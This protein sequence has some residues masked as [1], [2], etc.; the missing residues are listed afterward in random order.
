MRQSGNH[1]REQSG[2]QDRP[3]IPVAVILLISLAALWPALLNGGPFFMADTPSYIRGAASGFY[4]VFGLKTEWAHEFL[5][6]YGGALTDQAR[7]L[8]AG[9]AGA[10]SSSSGGQI[11]VTLS[12]RSI[13]YGAIL[14]LAYLAGSFWLV[15]V[16]QSV[17]AAVS[18]MFTIEAICSAAGVRAHPRKVLLIGLLAMLASPLAFFADYLMPDLF[19]GLA[20]LAA[21]NILFLWRELSH[22]RRGFWLALLTYSLLSHSVNLMMVAALSFIAVVLAWQRAIPVGRHPVVGI[23]V[24]L[25]TAVFGELAFAQAVVMA[26][27]APPVRPPFVAM[28]LIADGPGYDYLREHCPTKRFIYCRAVGQRELHHDSLLWSSDPNVSL[29]RGL[30]PQEQRQSAAQQGRFVTAVIRDRPL[31]VLRSASSNFLDQL[32]S[33]DL[34]VFNYTSGNRDRFQESVPAQLYEPITAT[35]AFRESMPTRAV[36][37][38]SAVAALMS[39]LT[40]MYFLISARGGEAM[41]RLRGHALCIMAGIMLNAAICGALSGPIGRYGMRVIWVLPVIAA[42]I[43]LTGQLRWRPRS[44]GN[45]G[46]SALA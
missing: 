38:L 24:C 43:V 13:F 33:F 19:G 1:A 37:T 34:N 10:A 2:A 21:T 39:V 15:V 41:S 17:L 23:V 6:V 14:F 32:F 16:A 28:R 26:T 20:L 22:V 36:E 25:M 46:S 45:S 9:E 42:A 35:K 44:T 18:I 3:W 11:A 4:K 12:G 31:E 27:G 7:P 30:P 5:R 40:L 29:F 8:L